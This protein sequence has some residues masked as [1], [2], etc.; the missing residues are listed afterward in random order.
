MVHILLVLTKHKQE[1]EL[2]KIAFPK[3]GCQNLCIWVEVQRSGIKTQ[4]G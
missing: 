4:D 3:M 2:K 1:I